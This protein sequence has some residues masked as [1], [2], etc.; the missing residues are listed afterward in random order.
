[1]TN[2]VMWLVLI[3]IVMCFLLHIGLECGRAGNSVVKLEVY[4][5]V[6]SETSMVH[7]TQRK[8]WCEHSLNP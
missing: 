4:I 8:E 1:M 3:H 2:R 5:L 6:S 7:K